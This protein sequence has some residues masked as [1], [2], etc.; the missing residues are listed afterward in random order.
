MKVAFIGNCQAQ[1]MQSWVGGQIA[2]ISIVQVPPV[3][4]LEEYQRASLLE[5]LD[6]CDYIFTQRLTDDLDAEYARTSFLRQRYGD[7]L[8]VWPNIYFDG[9][10]PGLGY[11]YDGTGGKYLSPLDEYHFS[12]VRTMFEAGASSADACAALTTEA[13]FQWHPDPVT[14][15][16]LRLREREDEV[17]VSISDYL[18]VMLAVDRTMFSMNHPTNATILE[19]LRR[20]FGHIGET[21]RLAGLVDNPFPLNKIIIPV[22][23]PIA[24]LYRLRFD[25]DC[26]P[27]K[28]LEYQV[29]NGR[30]EV[31]DRVRFYDAASLI[32][33][34]FYCYS[35]E[36]A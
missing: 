21:R 18:A 32:D 27:F 24:R 1:L 3:W 15:S 26:Q 5:G 13:L 34:F 23:Q 29:H 33:A 19:M 28:G 35:L 8:I 4:L 20:L 7:R 9:Y 11:R 36:S 25:E 2:D 12:F 6:Q 30:V 14:A 16:L 31:S 22:L 17:D 10:F